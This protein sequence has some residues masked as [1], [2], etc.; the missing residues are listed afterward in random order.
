MFA[1]LIWQGRSKVDLPQFIM[2]IKLFLRLSLDSDP[3][4]FDQRVGSLALL[5]TATQARG[6]LG[7][8]RTHLLQIK[9]N[10]QRRRIP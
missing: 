4:I 8:A 7:G 9:Q 3:E 5:P 2:C 1:S 10:Y 6:M